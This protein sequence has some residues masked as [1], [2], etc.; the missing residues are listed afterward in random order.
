MDRDGVFN[1]IDLHIN[2]PEQLDEALIPSSLAAVARLS[3]QPDFKLVL[4]TN[5]GGVDAGMMTPE[6]N[7]AIQERFVQRVEEAGGRMDAVLFCPNGKKFQV[8]AGEVDGRKP[9]AGMFYFA[10]QHFGAQVDLAD[11]YMIGDMTT[12]IGAGKKAETTTILVQTGFA[13]K[14]GK[15]NAQPDF[16]KKDLAEAADFIL[17]RE[18]RS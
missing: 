15:V 7:Q 1:A 4:V 9:D 5:Q 2:T 14:D 18:G 8:P 10:A 12:D 11:S 3:K 13:G 17:A 16:I 6:A